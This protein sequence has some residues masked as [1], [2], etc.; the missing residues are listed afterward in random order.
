MICDRICDA[1]AMLHFLEINGFSMNLCYN[2]IYHGWIH[3]NIEIYVHMSKKN[4]SRKQ[5]VFILN[6]LQL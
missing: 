2:M 1:A 6:Y 5:K 3:V 4:N